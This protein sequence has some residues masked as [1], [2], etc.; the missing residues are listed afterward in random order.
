MYGSFTEK[1]KA[2]A[3]YEVRGAI[4]KGFLVRPDICTLCG[5]D[6]MIFAHHSDYSDP[7]NVDWLCRKCHGK[8]HKELGYTETTEKSK[9]KYASISIYESTWFNLK[10]RARDEDTTLIKMLDKIAKE[11][12]GEKELTEEYESEPS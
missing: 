11:A 12:L 5:R 8:L 2:H 3:R 4:E 10:E 7:L 6:G 9:S 1:E